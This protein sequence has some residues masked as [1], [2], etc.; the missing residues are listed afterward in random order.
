MQDTD[1]TGESVP[2]E[3]KPSHLKRR[4]F[5]RT[6]VELR[7]P[8]QAYST[9]FGHNEDEY[10]TAVKVEELL[11]DDYVK[12]LLTKE[13]NLKNANLLFDS[14]DVFYEWMSIYTA[15]VNEIVSVRVGACR[16]C[17]GI[18]HRYQWTEAEYLKAVDY[19]AEHNASKTPDR[20]IAMPDLSGGLGY[21]KTCAP[22]D[23]CP[24]CHGQGESYVQL[25]DTT[26]LSP[27][28]RRLYRGAKVTK[29][30]IEVL[31]ADKDK[32]LDNIAKTLGM[33]AERFVLDV[34]QGNEQ[35]IGDVGEHDA[36]AAY[37]KLIEGFAN[38]VRH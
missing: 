35:T 11:K 18:A 31:M 32:A 16:H 22:N 15:D 34:R 37:Q 38:D 14:T 3:K 1:Q 29:N 8:V 24:E 25:H 7:N 2:P 26:K 12:D 19:V 30:G 5:V 27:G 10:L 6:L 4:L 23:S 13:R 20:H 36:Q 9:V 28:A 21:D 17:Y 33:F